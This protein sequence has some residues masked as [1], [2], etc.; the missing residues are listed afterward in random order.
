MEPTRLNR[1]RILVIEDDAANRELL[2]YN[3]V[4]S[5][6]QVRAADTGERG[7]S[8]LA[9]FTPDVIL[10]DLMLPDLPGT[11]ICRRIRSRADGPQP[12]IIMV[13]G[14]GDEL[15]RVGGFE[16]GADDYVVK[17]FSLRELSLRVNAL[18]QGRNGATTASSRRTP[19][20]STGGARRRFTVGPLRVDVDG[21][22]VFVEGKEV[23]VS[24]T[25]MR[26]L[27]CLL[28]HWGRVRLREN[29]LEEVWGYKPSIPTRT[30]DTHVK[31][32]RD[33]LGPAGELIETVRGT[34]YR[35]S[36]AYP[37]LLDADE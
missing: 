14:K 17:P 25:E 26:L 29:L 19:K 18:L 22:Y 10:L 24:A 9:A 23:H 13:T 37:I 2:T 8:M 3:F 36:D 5:G 7:L 35:L 30:V 27:V 12:A 33:K 4:L 21:H 28:E 20:R 1:R 34:G 16:V 11:E 32:L 15:D 31:R 6:Y